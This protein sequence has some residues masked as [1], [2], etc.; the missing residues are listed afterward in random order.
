MINYNTAYTE[1]NTIACRNNGAEVEAHGIGHYEQ[2]AYNPTIKTIA[3]VEGFTLR[4][5][6]REDVKY[7]I[8]WDDEILNRYPNLKTAE[9]FFIDFTG[10]TKSKYNK[11]KSAA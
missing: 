4:S 7:E 8:L 3:K 2:H 9:T 1:N 6:E 10:L 5:I 11:I